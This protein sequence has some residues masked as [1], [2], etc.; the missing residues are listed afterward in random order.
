[1]RVWLLRAV[2]DLMEHYYMSG[3]AARFFGSAIAYAILGMLLGIVMGMTQDHTQMP[4][5]AHL[6]VIGWVSFSIF[7]FFYYL[8]PEAAART[9]AVVHFW[10]AQVSFV[11][12]V[13]GLFLLMGGEKSVEPIVA[14]ASAGMLLSMVA[15]AFAALPVFRQAPAR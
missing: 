4:T 15:F 7:G 13:G 12:L 8:F 5:H 1:M 3:I 6:L 9:T 14:A 10:L 11:T 2:T